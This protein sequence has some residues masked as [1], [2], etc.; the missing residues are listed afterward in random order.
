MYVGSIAGAENRGQLTLL[1]LGF[2]IFRLLFF[3]LLLF[4]FFLLILPL[5]LLFSTLLCCALVRALA[6]RLG[7]SSFLAFSLLVLRY[8]MHRHVSEP[9][10]LR[11][12]LT[13][14]ARTSPGGLGLD[15]VVGHGREEVAN[16][17]FGTHFERQSLQ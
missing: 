13:R 15:H 4:L 17:I 6:A 1:K 2:G 11:C 9:S 10:Q 5:L 14:K 12:F 8:S 7:F 16:T 3:L